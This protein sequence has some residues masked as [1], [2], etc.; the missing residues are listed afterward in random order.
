MQT[1]TMIM[2]WAMIGGINL[3]ILYWITK[4]RPEYMIQHQNKGV[5]YETALLIIWFAFAFVIIPIYLIRF[6]FKAVP[7]W[8]RRVNL[9]IERLKKGMKK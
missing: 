8:E 7:E 6:F 9:K 4:K 3:I 1:E 2:T 5:L